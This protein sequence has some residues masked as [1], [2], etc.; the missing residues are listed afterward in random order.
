MDEFLKHLTEAREA[1]KALRRLA[2]EVARLREE[3]QVDETLPP[4]GKASRLGRIAEN[5]EGMALSTRKRLVEAVEAARAA[6]TQFQATGRVDAEALHRVP[7]LLAEGT[8]VDTLIDRARA[9]RDLE[10]LRAVRSES[11][12]TR[13]ERG[14]GHEEFIPAIEKAMLDLSSDVP[15]REFLAG[16][17]DLDRLAAQ[18]DS[19]A[20]FAL[21]AAR[22]DEK[23]LPRVRMALAENEAEGFVQ[24]R[25]P[26]A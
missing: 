15:E 5:A 2:D 24:E 12:W 11:L 18:V 7:R 26:G 22:G 10:T 9:L 1:L 21:K 13:S 16:S 4:D 19:T 23:G 25:G 14:L 8:P 20:D 17:V 6:R 3:V